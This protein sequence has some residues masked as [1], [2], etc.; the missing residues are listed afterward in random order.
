[1]AKLSD[2]KDPTYRAAL[3]ESEKL[4]DEGEYTKAAQKL[5]ETFIQLLNSRADLMPP[6]DFRDTQPVDPTG[7]PLVAEGTK[8]LQSIDQARAFRQKFWPGTGSISIVV[9]AGKPQIKYAKDRVSLSEASTY[10][11]YM[12]EKVYNAEKTAPVSA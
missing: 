10:F 9:E 6:P 7:K 3:E 5:A 1:M 8:G 11:E 12:V 4:L 2:I